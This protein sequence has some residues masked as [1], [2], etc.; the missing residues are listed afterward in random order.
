MR[1]ISFMAW[2]PRLEE[3]DNADN[4]FTQILSSLCPE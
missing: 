4:H 2:A 1:C 3:N